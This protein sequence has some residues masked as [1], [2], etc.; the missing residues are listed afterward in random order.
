MPLMTKVPP[1]GDNVH[2]LKKGLRL[3]PISLPFK[4]LPPSWEAVYSNQWF[5][6]TAHLLMRNIKHF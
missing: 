6:L 3:V 1:R 5:Y 4:A 2:V